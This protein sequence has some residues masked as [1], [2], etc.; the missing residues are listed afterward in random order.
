MARPVSKIVPRAA[1]HVQNAKR[2]LFLATRDLLDFE[3]NDP[4]LLDGRRKRKH[5]R[6]QREEKEAF[7]AA[8]RAAK[9]LESA[10]KRNGTSVSGRRKVLAQEKKRQDWLAANGTKAKKGNTG[11]RLA[12]AA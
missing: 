9:K 8:V 10:R 11:P 4:N 7:W 2:T 1:A 12:K 5:D 6:L 3:G